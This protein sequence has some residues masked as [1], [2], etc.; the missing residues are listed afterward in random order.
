MA[1][2]N[3]KEEKQEGKQ[4]TCLVCKLPV[5][6]GKKYCTIHEKAPQRRDGKKIQC[7]KVKSIV[8]YMKRNHK[9]KAERKH[10][11]ENIR[12]MVVDVRWNHPIKAGFVTTTIR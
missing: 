10:N 1:L 11:V 4:V 7:R 8:Q 9:R 3:Q 6:E 2:K 12:M 5:K